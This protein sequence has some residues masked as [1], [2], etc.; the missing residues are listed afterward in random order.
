MGVRPLLNNYI[1]SDYDYLMGI[2]IHMGRYLLLG[3][4]NFGKDQRDLAMEF[5]KRSRRGEAMAPQALAAVALPASATADGM[6]RARAYA[7]APP[8][9]GGSGGA[10]GTC[11][12]RGHRAAGTGSSVGAVVGGSGRGGSGAGSRGRGRSLHSTGGGQEAVGSVSVR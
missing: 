7:A 9:A 5:Y 6:K 2:M 12:G 10:G 1:D 8:G 3:I 11:R 4:G